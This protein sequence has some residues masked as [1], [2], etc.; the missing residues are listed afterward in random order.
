[1]MVGTLALA[2]A[3]SHAAGQFEV[4]MTPQTP[5]PGIEQAGLGRMTL[6]KQYQGDLVA[7]GLGEMLS[8]RTETAGSAGYV[9]MERVD[10]SLHGRK[11]SF[12]LQHSGTMNRGTPSLV[13]TVVPDSGNGELTGLSGSMTIEIKGGQHFYKMDYQLP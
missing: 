6:D 13:L 9:A 4:K 7:H 11:G 10:G 2:L 8:V 1:M 3:M 5:S 12:V